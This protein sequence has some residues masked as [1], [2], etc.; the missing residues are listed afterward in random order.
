VLEL[1]GMTE[2][3]VVSSSFDDN[4]KNTANYCIG[5]PH[6]NTKFYV[7]SANLQL[8]PIGVPG[9]LYIGGQSLAKGYIN[10]VNETDKRFIDNP[11]VESGKLYRTGDR[12]L[13]LDDGNYEFLGRM[14]NQVS[15]RGV[16]L[17]LGEIESIATEIDG[18]KQAIAIVMEFA[19]D[20]PSLVLYYTIED[21][22]EINNCLKENIR[23]RLAQL[24]PDHMLPSVLEVLNEF[25]L[26]P[27]GK[28]NRKVLPPPKFSKSHVEPQNDLEQRL[29][30]IWKTILGHKYICVEANFFEVG[31]HSLLATRLIVSVR[32]EF[33]ISLPLAELFESPTIRECSL[34]IEKALT[35]KYSKDIL[36]DVSKL[37]GDLSE[38]ILI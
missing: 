5:K 27:N 30:E 23:I 33:D 28:V 38:E 12:V 24:L 32:E 2:S 10:N 31:G 4:Q 19:K 9:E 15:L 25:P 13:Q 20:E 21:T 36:G 14:D 16:R 26:N 17:E 18:V 7:L 8:Q 1:Y 6:K 35:D 3:A 37:D 34:A 11:F 29:L 22:I